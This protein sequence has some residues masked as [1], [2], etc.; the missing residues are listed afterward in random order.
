MQE[1]KLE[2]LSSLLEIVVS[3]L[4]AFKYKKSCLNN[5]VKQSPK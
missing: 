5:Q 3:S 1:E 2:E 4:C